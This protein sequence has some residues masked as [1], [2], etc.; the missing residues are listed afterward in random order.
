MANHDH[1]KY[2]KNSMK[3]MRT[4]IMADMQSEITLKRHK[5][6]EMRLSIIS[7][8]TQESRHGPPTTERSVWMYAS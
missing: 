5:T 6:L 3:N 1:V 7:I 8:N 2:R 4:L